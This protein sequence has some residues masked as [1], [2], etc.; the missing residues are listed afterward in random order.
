[1]SPQTGKQSWLEGKACEGRQLEA[2]LEKVVV[3]G[4]EVW[5]QCQVVRFIAL[6]GHIE[7]G[8]ESYKVTGLQG[9]VPGWSVSCSGKNPARFLLF[10]FL[11]WSCAPSC[12]SY[13]LCLLINSKPIHL[14]PCPL[15]QLQANWGGKR[16]PAGQV[17][18]HDLLLWGVQAKNRFY[19]FKWFKKN[20]KK[21]DLWHMKILWN[22]NLS[23]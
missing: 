5:K 14:P 10:P 12:M 13:E 1:M 2:R 23:S 19:I 15:P 3:P 18:A 7:R 17:L 8:C 9:S 4:D 11:H 16:R 6:W 21:N 20:Q 22:S